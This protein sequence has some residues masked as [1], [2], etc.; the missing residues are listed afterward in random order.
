MN[1]NPMTILIKGNFKAN[2]S[3]GGK[4]SVLFTVDKVV[5]LSFLDISKDKSR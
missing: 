1:E 3:E 4:L 5:S 2:Q